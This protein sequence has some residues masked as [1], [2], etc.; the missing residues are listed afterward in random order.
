MGRIMAALR[1]WAGLSKDA[2]WLKRQGAVVGEDVEIYDLTCSRNDAKCVEI[3]SHVTIAGAH[4]LTH[5]ASPKRFVGHDMNRVGRVVIGDNVFIGAGTII[6]PG[7]RIGSNVV[8]GAGSVVT[9]DV[10]ENT[11]VA[12]NPARQISTLEAFV[13]KHEAKLRNEEDVFWDLKRGK[14]KGEQ[15]ARFNRRIDGK[16]VYLGKRDEEAR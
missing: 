7:V 5:D 10:G 1:S 13:A 9:R 4:I 6:L 8:V 2:N 11:V 14:L 16:T 12:G 15:L 3:G